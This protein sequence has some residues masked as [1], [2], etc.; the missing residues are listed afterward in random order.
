MVIFA[1][2]TSVIFGVIAKETLRDQLWTA[3]RLFG[4]F[5]G[6]AVVLGWLMYFIP[7]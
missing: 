6:V 2:L 7:F 5:I 4:A 3:G 1:A